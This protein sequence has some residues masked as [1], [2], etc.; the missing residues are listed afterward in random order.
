MTRDASQDISNSLGE[1]Y[2]E[3]YLNWMITGQAAYWNRYPR[4]SITSDDKRS[5]QKMVEVPAY[6]SRFRIVLLQH[7]FYTLR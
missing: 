6:D 4:P 1:V 7:Y 5:N 2:T 3:L